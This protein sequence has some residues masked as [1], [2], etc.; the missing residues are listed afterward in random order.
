M[1]ERT[2]D[3]AAAETAKPRLVAIRP[4]ALGDALLTLPVLAWLRGQVPGVRITL[5]ARRDVLPLASGSGVADDVSPYDDT[6]WSALF[7]DEPPTPRGLAHDVCSGA[8]VAAWTGADD[9]VVRRILLALGASAVVVAPGKPAPSSQRH[10]ALQ[11]SDGLA[12]L[13]FPAPTTWEELVERPPLR[14]TDASRDRISSWLR[15][16]GIESRR[17]VAAHPGSGGD[18]KRWPAESFAAVLASLAA[19]GYTPLLI[20]GPHD[21][22]VVREIQAAPWPQA[23]SAPVARDLPVEDLAALLGQ[24]AAYVGNDSGVT[25]LAALAGC[26]T[27]AIFGPSDDALWRPLG[28]RVLVIRA[29]TDRVE[30]VPT[31]SVAALLRDLLAG[32]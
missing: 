3:D 18:A 15:A 13:G 1:G 29:A 7:A 4:G 10:M 30:D 8:R 5:V 26:P 25:H 21:A 32:K 17:L 14:P 27:V 24:C 28:R 12:R 31:Q 23:G 2:V 19:E 11:L 22:V 16:H 9:G 20:E 6:A